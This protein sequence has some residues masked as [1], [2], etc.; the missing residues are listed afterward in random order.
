MTVNEKSNLLSHRSSALVFCPQGTKGKNHQKHETNG[1]LGFYSHCVSTASAVASLRNCSE[2]YD[3]MAGP[4]TG[5]VSM[6]LFPGG[7][8]PLPTLSSSHWRMVFST[9]S[10]VDDGMYL[11]NSLC[12]GPNALPWVTCGGCSTTDDPNRYRQKNTFNQYFPP[13]ANGTLDTVTCWSQLYTPVC[14]RVH[15]GNRLL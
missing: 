4:A 3:C 15:E 5:R 13:P 7:F 9:R 10:T 1:A 11:M 12:G 6:G 8:R 14:G 2:L